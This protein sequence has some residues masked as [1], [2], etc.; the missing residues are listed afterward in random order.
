M[1]GRIP[2]ARAGKASLAA[3]VPPA[4]SWLLSG[5]GI[6]TR[7]QTSKT[8]AN[9]CS[10]EYGPP[11]LLSAIFP[12]QGENSPRVNSMSVAG[13]PREEALSDRLG[14]LAE[15]HLDAYLFYAT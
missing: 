2:A 4:L 11:W 12:L 6:Q 3:L 15:A 10:L 8:Q 14:T 13:Q 1:P 7:A 9:S 5:K